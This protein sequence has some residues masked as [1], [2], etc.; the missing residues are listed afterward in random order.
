MATSNPNGVEP[1]ALAVEHRHVAFLRDY[2]D[3][4]LAGRQYDLACY[5]DQLADPAADETTVARLQRWLHD[6]DRHELTGSRDELHSQILDALLDVDG[7]NEYARVV[8]EHE[9]FAHLLRGLG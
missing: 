1:I 6:L 4:V 9:A 3:A 5:R 7:S 2:F 8:D